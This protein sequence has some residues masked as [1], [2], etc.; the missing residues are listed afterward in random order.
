MLAAVTDKSKETEN[1]TH[2]NI[3]QE[4]YLLLKFHSDEVFLVG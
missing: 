1:N 2:S 3:T 4:L